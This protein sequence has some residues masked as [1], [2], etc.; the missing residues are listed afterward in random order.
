MNVKNRNAGNL[1][2]A[3]LMQEAGKESFRWNDDICAVGDEA[4]RGS[5]ETLDN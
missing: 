3:K 4:F 1:R 2:Y 5:F